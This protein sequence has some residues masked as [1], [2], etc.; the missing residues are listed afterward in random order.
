MCEFEFWHDLERRFREARERFGDNLSA[1]W[2]G[3][4]SQPNEPPMVSRRSYDPR[5]WEVKEGADLFAVNSVGEQWRVSA[6]GNKE[7]RTKFARL[8]ERAAVGLGHTDQPTA[9]FFW[10]DRLKTESP[11]FY[12]D[13]R[14]TVARAGGI[15]RLFEA[16][17]EYCFNLATGC[18]STQPI[19]VETHD[20]P[21]GARPDVTTR[22]NEA[23]R[24]GERHNGVPS[25]E[26][27]AEGTPAA[28]FSSSAEVSQAPA[29]AGGA[30]ADARHPHENYQGSTGGPPPYVFRRDQDIWTLTFNGQT[31][32]LRNCKGLPYIAELLKAK[33]P[34]E[35]VE[36]RGNGAGRGPIEV[37]RGMPAADEKAI[38]E[39]E[40]ELKDLRTRMN[41][42]AANDWP[43]RSALKEEIEHIE[44]YLR[45]AKNRRGS[46]RNVGG[47]IEHARQAVSMAMV[48]AFKKI[49]I[50]NPEL[51]D[52]L[53][54][55]ISRGITCEY[56]P[57]TPLDWEF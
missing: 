13:I 24:L 31:L 45:E 25:S 26:A 57:R 29:D 36:L 12:D 47:S 11:L 30:R 49:A 3:P 28:G 1:R 43:R 44:R 48:R 56:R 40:A 23:V 37:F 41:S 8:A 15:K 20:I 50:Q 51:A 2:I 21:Q 39:A 35:A 38:K 18:M 54:R 55:S 33:R 17:A 46:A 19:A 22:S 6:T 34:I 14:L 5:G 52:H 16:A 27:T 7:E 42:L 10:L 9:L 4:D 53:D 32:R